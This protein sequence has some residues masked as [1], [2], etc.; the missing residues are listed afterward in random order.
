M[1]VIVPLHVNGANGGTNG[2]FSHMHYSV[3]RNGPNDKVRRH[4][5]VRI[6][7]TT[8]IVQAKAPNADYISEF[9]EP[10]SIERY[11]KMLRFFDSNLQRFG[12]RTSA[13]WLDCLDKWGS[14]VDWCNENTFSVHQSQSYQMTQCIVFTY[15]FM[16][17]NL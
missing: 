5:L 17:L 2:L 6:F 12:N 9:G 3:N 16:W 15:R 1:Q 13:A 11:E 7:D 10:S 14:D 4:N 8:F